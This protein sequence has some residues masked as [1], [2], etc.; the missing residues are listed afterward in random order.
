MKRSFILIYCVSI[1][2]GCGS[3]PRPEEGFSLCELKKKL[4]SGVK[5]NDFNLFSKAFYLSSYD[6]KEKLK[7]SFEL[8]SAYAEL[9]RVL[10]DVFP[11]FSIDDFYKFTP[12]GN[13]LS[14]GA[15]TQDIEDFFYINEPNIGLALMYRT[16]RNDLIFF[17]VIEMKEASYLLRPHSFFI[18][19]LEDHTDDIIISDFLT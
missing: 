10:K 2:F 9:F 18:S 14:V 1:F 13:Y 3:S 11:E 8:Q 6:D 12:S 7:K 15:P 17:R 5:N 16:T 19:F 4:T